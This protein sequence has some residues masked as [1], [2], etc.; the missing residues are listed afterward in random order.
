MKYILACFAISFL[1]IAFL[2]RLVPVVYAAEAASISDK[3]D[4]GAYLSLD[5][6][7]KWIVESSDRNT[8]LDEKLKKCAFYAAF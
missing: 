8:A 6:G 4:D 2:F 5:D 3:S 1:L 7:T